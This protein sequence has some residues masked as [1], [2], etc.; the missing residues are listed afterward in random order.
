MKLYSLKDRTADTAARHTYDYCL[1][2]GI[3]RT[4]YSDKDPAF[5][6]ELF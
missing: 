1:Q 3:P 5:Q 6:A 4:I 2:F